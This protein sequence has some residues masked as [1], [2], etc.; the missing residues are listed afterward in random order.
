MKRPGAV[1]LPR[2]T[3]PSLTGHEISS[4]ASFPRFGAFHRMEAIEGRPAT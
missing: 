2:R 3:A 4:M 1:L